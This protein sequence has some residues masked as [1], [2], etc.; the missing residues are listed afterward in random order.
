MNYASIIPVDLAN[1]PGIRT[2]LFVSGCNFHCHDC[3]NQDQ[4]DFTYGRP[5]DERAARLVLDNVAKPY[6]AGLSIL[7]GDPLWQNENGMAWLQELCDAVHQ[8]DKT[9]WLWSGFTW[10][11]L[12]DSV[13][14]FPDTLQNT[15]LAVACLHLVC[16]CDVF[17]DGPFQKDL[18][19]LSLAWRGSSNQRVIDVRKTIAN[20]GNVV[21]WEGTT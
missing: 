19:D 7:G 4:Q 6:C 18:K 5:F 14:C 17:V 16:A 20:G 2:S 9:V 1:G 10:E 3:F 15:A 11:A 12:V 13:T 8:M 21:L